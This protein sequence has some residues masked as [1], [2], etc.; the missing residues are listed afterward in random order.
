MQIH[1]P[2]LY[3]DSNKKMKYLV[4][5][6]LENGNGVGSPMVV[7]NLWKY[8]RILPFLIQDHY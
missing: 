1:I 8:F 6:L 2:E 5:I 7:F 3:H 4:L